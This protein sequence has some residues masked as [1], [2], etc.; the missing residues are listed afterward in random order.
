MKDIRERLR[1]LEAE[2]SERLAEKTVFRLADG[3]LFY[4][5]CDP[6]TYLLMNGV[7]TTRGRIVAYVPSNSTGERDP[8]SVAI[9]DYIDE[10][11][12]RRMPDFGP[13]IHRQVKQ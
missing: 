13:A 6:V 3:T 2:Y 7:E 9:M 8:L 5:D 10:L 11:T 4:T 1:R 12:E